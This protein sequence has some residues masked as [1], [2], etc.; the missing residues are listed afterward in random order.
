LAT[1]LYAPGWTSAVHT[2]LDF[3][4]AAIGFFLLVRWK[5]R[6]LVVG[7]L[8]ALAGIAEASCIKGLQPTL[9]RSSIDDTD[10]PAP[11]TAALCEHNCP[12]NDVPGE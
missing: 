9:C 2:E 11:A 4:I 6:P 8:C 5:L 12:K 1:A 7:A 3:A 10:P